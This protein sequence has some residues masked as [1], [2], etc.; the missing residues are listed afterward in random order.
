LKVRADE[1][2]SIR[3]VRAVRDIAL[4]QGWELSHVREHHESRTLDETWLPR[5]A[6]ESGN[7]ILSAD[8]KMLAR[9]NQIRAI[10]ATGL[11]GIFLPR[12]W[13]ESRRHIQAAHILYWWPRIEETIASSA[14][15]ACWRVPF[16]FTDANIEVLPTNF[17]ALVSPSPDPERSTLPRDRKEDTA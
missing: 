17:G 15:S 10:A 13:A 6:Q 9:P 12:R 3:I 16:G 11:V 8:R 7:A 1:N 14:K 2:V 5:F 4:S